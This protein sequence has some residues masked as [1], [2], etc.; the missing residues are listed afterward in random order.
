MENEIE[1]N[2]KTEE[3]MITSENTSEENAIEEEIS[4]HVDDI[5]GG[6]IDK[7]SAVDKKGNEII[8]ENVIKD[9]LVEVASK[10]TPKKKKKSALTSLLMLAINIV[11]VYF[12]ASSYPAI[13]SSISFTTCPTVCSER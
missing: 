1:V 7:I 4:Q 6:S 9:K 2:S 3:D 8:N 12:L 13:V 11:L 10:T 5:V